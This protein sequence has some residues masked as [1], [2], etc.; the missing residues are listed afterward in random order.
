MKIILKIFCI[1]LLALSVSCAFDRKGSPVDD[2]LYK[3]MPPMRGFHKQK[4]SKVD[5]NEDGR[6]DTLVIT[7]QNTNGDIMKEYRTFGKTWGWKVI[8]GN[9]PNDCDN[10]YSI[11]D[12]NADGYLDSKRCGELGPVIPSWVFNYWF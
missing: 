4:T 10:Q 5:W 9:D 6:K 7:Y 1:A 12:E 3:Q 2:G 8:R 11:T